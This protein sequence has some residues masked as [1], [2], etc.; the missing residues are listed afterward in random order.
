MRC[1]NMDYKHSL[2]LIV[3]IETLIQDMYQLK[4]SQKL[5][6]SPIH[7]KVG[8]KIQDALYYKAQEK[9]WI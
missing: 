3:V 7:K 1:L 9:L 6:F 5:F 2:Y 8:R 4:Y